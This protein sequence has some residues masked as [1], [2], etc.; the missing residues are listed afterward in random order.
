[1]KLTYWMSLSAALLGSAAAQAN[2]LTATI[3]TL[4]IHPPTNSGYVRLT[5][6]PV[7]NDGACTST[8]AKGDLNDDRFMIYIWPV[9]MS[10]KSQGKSVTISVSDCES[11]YPR[12][13]WIQLNS[14]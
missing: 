6:V 2:E 14:T 9:L 7:F 12:I 8:W 10:A 1:M 3:E 4:Q 11:G 13:A 5:G